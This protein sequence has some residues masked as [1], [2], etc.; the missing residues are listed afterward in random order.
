[1]KKIT[2]SVPDDLYEEIEKHKD[3]LNYSDIF[4]KAFLEEMKKLEEKP[5]MIKEMEEFLE[6]RFPDREAIRNAEIERF[7][8][9]WGKDPDYISDTDVSPGGTSP[10]VNVEKRI[11]VK[12]GRTLVATLR[13]LNRSD[14]WV[15]D[16]ELTEFKAENWK[17]I[18]GG[19]L[20][21]LVEYLKSVGF[22]V[23]E[24]QFSLMADYERWITHH[25]KEEARRLASDS[26]FNYFGLF[27]KDEKDVIFIATRRSKKSWPIP[28]N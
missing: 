13:I 19:H 24:K 14:V 11:E 10:Y 28:H 5:E 7:R 26:D 17:E 16:D 27:A 9:R 4:R 1:M 18:S 23:G 22:T 25:N 20:A 15:Q 8:K 21:D 3:E 12:A 2:L 6:A